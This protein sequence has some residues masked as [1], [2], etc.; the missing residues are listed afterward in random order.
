[1]VVLVF[2]VLAVCV[3]II[4]PVLVMLSVIAFVLVIFSQPIS[5]AERHRRDDRDF[6]ASVRING[7]DSPIFEEHPLTILPNTVP[8]VP[9]RGIQP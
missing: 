4:G 1:M 3:L 5:N 2:V 7:M 6:L 9:R 8:W